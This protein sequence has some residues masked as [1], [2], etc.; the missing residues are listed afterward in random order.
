MLIIALSVTDILFLMFKLTLTKN[1][2]KNRCLMLFILFH[3]VRVEAFVGLFCG[4]DC[5]G[6]VDI[7]L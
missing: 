3:I 5:I 7:F 1:I 6:W 4:C 2:G